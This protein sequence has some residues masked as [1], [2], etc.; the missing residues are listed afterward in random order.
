MISYRMTTGRSVHRLGRKHVAGHE[1]ACRVRS[2]DGAGLALP[3]ILETGTL[4][5][6]EQFDP[7]RDEYTFTGHY[8]DTI[9]ESNSS[10]P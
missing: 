2:A 5:N 1:Q 3:S 9:F 8:R 6:T 10:A 7:E 4:A